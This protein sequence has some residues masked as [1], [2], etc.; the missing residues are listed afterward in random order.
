MPPGCFGLGAAG[1]GVG[2]QQGLW[3]PSGRVGRIASVESQKAQCRSYAV[4]GTRK[5][6]GGVWLRVLQKFHEFGKCRRA[7]AVR[8]CPSAGPILQ[9]LWEPADLNVCFPFIC[10]IL[11]THAL[12]NL[13][14]HI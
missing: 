8:G 6:G 11:L 7:S 5:I 1:G 14:L 4:M 9:G 13:T 12:Q 3:H 10:Q 2:V